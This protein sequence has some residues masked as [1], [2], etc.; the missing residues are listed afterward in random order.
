MIPIKGNVQSR[1]ARGVKL[2]GRG[3]V[4]FGPEK[5]K[6]GWQPP[7]EG[8]ACVFEPGTIPGLVTDD[9]TFPLRAMKALFRTS[10]VSASLLLTP[11]VALA[12]GYKVPAKS[13]EAGRP[14]AP[15]AP[16][17]QRRG[18][19]RTGPAAQSPFKLPGVAPGETNGMPGQRQPAGL[20]Q[21][22]YAGK[23]NGQGSWQLPGGPMISF[24][25]RV[26]V[27]RGAQGYSISYAAD[28]PAVGGG[29]QPSPTRWEANFQASIQTS[30]GAQPGRQQGQAPIGYGQAPAGYGNAPAGYGAAQASGGQ[31]FL[32]GQSQNYRATILQTN[33]QQGPWAATIG[34]SPMNGA[35]VGQVGNPDFG[36][37]EFQLTRSGGSLQQPKGIDGA[38]T[39]TAFDEMDDGRPLQY[40]V[41]LNVTRTPNGQVAA[42]LQTTIPYPDPSSGQTYQLLI[43]ETFSG[44]EGQSGA[45]LQCASV[46]LMEGNSRQVIETFPATLR[47]TEG[48]QGMT[49]SLGNDEMGW[50]EIRFQRSGARPGMGP[51]MT[52]GTHPGGGYGYGPGFGPRPGVPQQGT[53]GWSDEG[54]LDGEL[55]SIDEYYGGNRR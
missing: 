42:K 10:I 1:A 48:P 30:P 20:P 13:P 46:K 27:Q 19:F 35:L 3:K 7:T 39:G 34:L 44:R 21:D 11:A 47:L 9:S 38:W 32:M 24:P 2:T 14:Q 4:A 16:V 53:S 18:G 22:A 52:P 45:V 36:F 28:I 50:T 26:E 15:A 23:W 12:Q 49:G 51:G 54:E 25:V 55:I 40:Q 6:G 5:L 29:I 43:D 33:A 17:T 8:L 31:Q 41:S 37:A